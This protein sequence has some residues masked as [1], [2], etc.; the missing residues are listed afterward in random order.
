[1]K[2]HNDDQSATGRAFARFIPVMREHGFGRSKAY[3]LANDGLIETFKIGK[4]KFV[5]IDSVR[6]LPQRIAAAKPAS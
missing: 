4:A 1:M 3:E 6:S 2:T 5:Y